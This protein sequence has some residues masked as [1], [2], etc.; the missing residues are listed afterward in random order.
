MPLGEWLSDAWT[1][2]V[3]VVSFVGAVVASGHAILYKRDT[4][5]TV[6]WVSFIWFVPIGGPLGYLLLGINR[7]KRRAARRRSS[8]PRREPSTSGTTPLA[9]EGDAE[10]LP[11]GP[12]VVIEP[13]HLVRLVRIVDNVV[14]LPLLPGNRVTP[15]FDGDEAYPAMLE[16]IGQARNSIGLYT[17]IFDRDAAGRQFVEA[18]RAAVARGVAVR[19]LIDDTGARY[20]WPTVVHTLRQAGVHV[21]RFLPTLIPFG[22]SLSFN[23]RTHRKILV[24]DG[25]VAFTG[26]MNI[27]AGHMRDAQGK[28]MI[29]DSHY[30][31]E[32]PV[33][34][35][36]RDVF[37]DDWLFTTREMLGGA[38]WC[39]AVDGV[40]EVFARAIADGPDETIDRLRWTYLG[41]LTAA[42]RRICIV[43]PYFLP[44]PALISALNTAALRGVSVEILIPERNNIRLV[45]WACTAHL[46]QVLERG[47]R[48]FVAPPPFD[49]NKL[50]VVDDA[51][52]LV[53]S[54][55]WDPRSLRLNFEF[56]VECY[57]VPLTQRLT[58]WFD[59]RRAAAREITL[60]EVNARS[61]PIR[62]RDGVARLATPFL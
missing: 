38:A 14:K 54:A 21:G 39:P 30:R 7:I 55:N 34:A 9:G 4:R 40:G 35:Q 2:I 12:S 3:A 28:L 61:L 41:A 43:T 13:S 49:H 10:T 25:R 60:R 19:V 33:V 6:L 18:L 47:C 58:A 31:F 46:W 27:R 62:L 17:Y 24:V 8:G 59:T 32:G 1:I 5:A 50:M 26:G 37:I 22:V 23:M 51:W 53:G 11:P 20:S 16:A 15:L 44:D 36:I 57:S 48:V 52:A 56:N 42:Q 45:E 29:Q